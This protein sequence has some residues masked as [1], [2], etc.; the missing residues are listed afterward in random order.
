MAA[1]GN[2]SDALIA[3]EQ[4]LGI[5][6]STQL[7][8]AKMDEKPFA[9]NIDETLDELIDRGLAQRPDLMAELANVRARQADVRK[10]RAAYYP[11]IS[12]DAHGG[13]EKLDLNEYS[14]PFF[15]NSK[16]IYGVGV[17]IELPIFDGFV[18]AS[19]LRIAKSQLRSADNAL[20]NSRNAVIREVWQA[21]TDLKTALRK[22][23]SATKLLIAAQSAFDATLEAYRNGLGTYVDT[24]NAQ[25][26]L[27]AAQGVVVDTR[28]SIYTSAAALALSVGDL[29]K[30][31]SPKFVPK[32]P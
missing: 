7:Q 25:R 23:E 19:N 1:R 5:V 30:P 9:D 6:P 8:V 17:A 14:S 32:Q 16:P 12:L 28:S 4:S 27:T 26:D 18:R 10:A 20:A 15:E 31:P 11:K 13:W 21:D 22:Q 29:A 2:L 24:A 3:L